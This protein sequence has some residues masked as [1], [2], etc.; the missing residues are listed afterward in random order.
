[1]FTYKLTSTGLATNKVYTSYIIADSKE[2]ALSICHKDK[3]Y[4]HKDNF[5]NIEPESWNFCE[6]VEDEVF[7]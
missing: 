6:K 4:D 5:G 3:K 7:I 1:M 2:E